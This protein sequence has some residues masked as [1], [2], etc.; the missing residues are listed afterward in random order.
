MR[1]LQCIKTTGNRSIAR[2][3]IVGLLMSIA[4]ALIIV[5]GLN[6]RATAESDRPST[7]ANSTSTFAIYAPYWSVEDGFVSTIEM[8]NYR[9]DQ[10]LSIRPVLYPLH[11][12]AV[13]L[14]PVA[15]NPSETR[16]LNINDALAAQHKHFTVGAVEIKYADVTES[17]FGANLTVLNKE[18]SL[19]YDF[20][21]RIPEMSSRLEGMWWFYDEHTDG[22]VAVQNTSDD[23]V[24]A[25]PTFYAQQHPRQLEPLHL[26][27]HEMR[28]IELRKEL[29]ELQLGGTTGGG[30]TIESSESNA[31][32]A[33]GGLV[34]PEIGFSAPLRMDDPTMQAMRTSRLGKTLHAL[35]VSIGKDHSMMPMGLPPGTLM[36][37]IVNLRN[38]T[39]GNIGVKL[40]FRY[41]AGSSTQS[42][43]MPTMQLG[44]QD[45][46]RVNLL[47]YWQSG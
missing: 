9:V 38:V 25:T 41:Q 22:F 11:G 43:T 14:D 39:D 10:S 33:G 26:Q 6:S 8:K 21:F 7:Q 12:P 31:V 1:I 23:A 44:A 24:T 17:V 2:A 30:I 42:F 5:N 18:K 20:Q 32:I 46:K 36:N 35:M 19:I 3:T 16:L 27:P 13:A 37:P 29:N 40:V 47:P 4:V 15:L 28:L 45:V 34:N